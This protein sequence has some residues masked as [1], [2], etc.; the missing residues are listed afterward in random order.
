MPSLEEVHRVH[1]IELGSRFECECGRVHE[2]PLKLILIG[3]DSAEMTLSLIDK[4]SIKGSACVIHDEITRRIAGERIAESLKQVGIDVI[5]LLV[6]GPYE[7][8]SERIREALVR[9]GCGYLFAVG[10][11]TVIDVGKLAAYRAG[12]PFISI[13]TALSHDGIASPT[14]SV[15]SIEDGLKRSFQ[16]SPPISLI[17]DLKVLEDAPRRMLIAGCGD[18]VSRATSLKDWELGRDERGEYYCK[19][20]AEL[21]LSSFKEALRFMDLGG[22]DLKMQAMTITKSSL[23]MI[24][25]GS[26]RPC[27]GSEHIFSHYIDLYPERSSMH[28]EQVGLG[29]ILMSKYHSDHNDNWWSEEIF[30]WSS[31]KRRLERVGF[32][33]TLAE[34][35]I[36]KEMAVKAL[37]EGVKLRPRKYTILHKRPIRREE[38]LSLLKEVELI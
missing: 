9:R 18:I 4:L 15:K 31:I 21:A 5:E 17:I 19:A 33:S 3:D 25:A 28:G 35:G 34:I 30:Q 24:L 8:E 2:I 27:S 20:A 16:A 13:P 36:S 23:S 38:A 26:S 32:P 22:E 14:A 11:G 6:S 29:T 10:G 7:S 37:C 12:I 1:G